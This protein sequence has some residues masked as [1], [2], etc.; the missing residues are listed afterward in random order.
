[1][2]GGVAKTT[3]SIFF[4]CSDRLF[5][6]VEANSIPEDYTW[7]HFVM[8]VRGNAVSIFIDG[9][10]VKSQEMENIKLNPVKYSKI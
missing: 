3:K 10:F 2:L 8:V 4:A 1:M 6:E 5:I 7:F 9:V